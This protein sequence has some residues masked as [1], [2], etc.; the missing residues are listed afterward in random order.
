MGSEVITCPA[1][2]DQQR[3]H[4]HDGTCRLGPPVPEPPEFPAA[5]EEEQPRY[6]CP[7]CRGPHRPHRRD[8]TCALGPIE[9]GAN[10]IMALRACTD[11]EELQ[12]AEVDQMVWQTITKDSGAIVAPLKDVRLAVGKDYEDWKQAMHVEY[13]NML[14]KGGLEEVPS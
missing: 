8:H 6:S 4:T 5:E 14:E 3:P 7:A 10:T 2:N 11:E 9:A 1:C 12:S 13:A